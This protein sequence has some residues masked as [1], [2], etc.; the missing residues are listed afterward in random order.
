MMLRGSAM[1]ARQS[2][3]SVNDHTSN[4]R[5]PQDRIPTSGSEGQKATLMRRMK[6][7]SLRLIFDCRLSICEAPPMVA[8]HQYRAQGQ[9]ISILNPKSTIGNYRA[10]T[11]RDVKNE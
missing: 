9:D 5:N 10:L 7:C 8:A 6:D 11:P 3:L 4:L 2:A 1:S